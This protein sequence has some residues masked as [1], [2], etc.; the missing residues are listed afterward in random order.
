M[1]GKASLEC[2]WC[3]LGF[4]LSTEPHLGPWDSPQIL[5]R[6][7][8]SQGQSLCGIQRCLV[9]ICPFFIGP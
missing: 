3:P 9:N 7:I 8:P 4:I 5:I 2:T 6:Y 1:G